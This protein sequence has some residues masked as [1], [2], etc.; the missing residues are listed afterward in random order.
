MKR[1]A[2]PWLSKHS[3]PRRSAVFLLL[4]GFAIGCGKSNEVA[5]DKS[6]A[7][8]TSADTNSTQA[9]TQA[10][11][12]VEQGERAVPPEV[13]TVANTLLGSSAEVLAFGDLA[14]N[15][16]EQALVVNRVISSPRI[17]RET[18]APETEGV[19]FTRAAVIERDGT[20][21]IQVLRCDEHLTNPKGFLAGAPLSPVTGWRVQPVKKPDEKDDAVQA[22]YFTPLEAQ[23]TARAPTITVSWNPN[24]R[25]YQ[26]VDRTTQQF[27]GELASLETPASKLR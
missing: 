16:H 26:V 1:F 13:Q 20:R 7:N 9:R 10:G 5:A 8:G 3:I 21:W 22:F 18:A 12:P 23:D 6:A 24:V 2:I 19:P 11:D 25:R 17:A 15:G 14:H 27:L 4:M